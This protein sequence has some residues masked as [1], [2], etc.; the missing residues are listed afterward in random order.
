LWSLPETSADPESACLQ[1][2]GRAP[3]SM[4]CLPAFTHVFTHF[5]L[6]IKP[7]LIAVGGTAK[8]INEPGKVWMEIDEAARAAVPKPVRTI[9][10]SLC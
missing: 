3:E 6:D 8:V 10:E 7:V 9:L 1:L 5:K 4:Q 2:T